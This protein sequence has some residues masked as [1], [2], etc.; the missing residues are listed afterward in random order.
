M[1]HRGDY[2]SYQQE[3]VDRVEENIAEHKR[4]IKESLTRSNRTLEKTVAVSTDTSLELKKQGEQI[5]QI[6][7]DVA[8]T[9]QTVTYADSLVKSIDSLWYAIN[10]FRSKPKAVPAETGAGG[11]SSSKTKAKKGG[12]RGGGGSTSSTT[13][14][15]A[16][17][18][19]DENAALD[20]MARN[21]SVLKQQS[22]AAG[23]EI[24]R[25]NESLERTNASA[26]RL[27]KR[28][29]VTTSNIKRMT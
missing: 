19:E 13:A 24:D 3:E 23:H 6:E 20:N 21:L 26:D 4:K 27:G 12:G 10:P 9:H 28:I 8:H 16:G 15:A 22:I 11:S 14:R 17:F 18:D 25:Q 5:D 2:D 29:Q 7:R 1:A